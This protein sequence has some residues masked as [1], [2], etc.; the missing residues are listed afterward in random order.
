VGNSTVVERNKP[1]EV[2]DVLTGVLRKGARRL[3]SSALEAKVEAFIEEYRDIPLADGRQRVVRNGYHRTREIQTGIGKVTVRAPR[4]E[5][6]E[7]GV[8]KI[9]LQ[10]SILPPYLRRSRSIE[11]L[12]PWLYLKGISTCKVVGSASGRR[13][14]QEMAQWDSG[15]L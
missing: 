14:R 5:D 7:S 13:W 11:A 6:R 3:L 4:T 8:E 15:L 9:R 10:S 1:E 2:E 12:L